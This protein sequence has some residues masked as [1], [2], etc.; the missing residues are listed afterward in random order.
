[1]GPA[2]NM[3]SQHRGAKGYGSIDGKAMHSNLYGGTASAKTQAFHFAPK[4]RAGN[5]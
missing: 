5:F 3:H 2:V 1:M 4:G